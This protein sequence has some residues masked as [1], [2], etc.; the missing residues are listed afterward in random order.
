MKTFLK[1]IGLV[2]LM[3]LLVAVGRTVLLPS[4]QTGQGAVYTGDI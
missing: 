2:V 1:L 3:L 4:K